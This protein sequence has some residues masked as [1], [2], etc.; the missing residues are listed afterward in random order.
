MTRMMLRHL[1]SMQG[2]HRATATLRRTKPYPTLRLKIGTRHLSPDRSAGTCLDTRS[3]SQRLTCSKSN[4][5]TST[6]PLWRRSPTGSVICNACGLYFKARH[7]SRPIKEKRLAPTSD[8]S[9]ASES[10]TRLSSVACS[11]SGLLTTPDDN[12]SKAVPKGS[13]PG[14]GQCN[15]TGGAAACNGCPAY[16]NRLS[17]KAQIINQVSLDRSK[18]AS[19]EPTGQETVVT[20]RRRTSPGEVNQHVLADED[21]DEISCQNCGTSITPLW[22]RDEQG[23]S[24]CNACGMLI[25][26]SSRIVLT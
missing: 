15:G 5:G 18:I 14:G 23:R 13:C 20:E 21:A 2:S 19:R 3:M 1:S 12:G 17:K 7:T 6:T 16:N 9:S 8:T 4:C 26:T 25:S 24:I 22:R 11:E 10:T